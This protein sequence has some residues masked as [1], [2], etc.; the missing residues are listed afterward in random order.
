MTKPSIVTAAETGG[1]FSRAVAANQT[2]GGFLFCGDDM[3]TLD[4]PEFI[5]LGGVS[6]SASHEYV[7]VDSSRR[8]G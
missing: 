8:G 1:W 6:F 3:G 5:P 7:V 4:A 2:K